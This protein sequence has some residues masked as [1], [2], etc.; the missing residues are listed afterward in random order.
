MSPEVVALLGAIAV[1]IAGVG[2]AYLAARSAKR[3]NSGNIQTSTAADLWEQSSEMNKSLFSQLTNTQVQLAATQIQLRDTSVELRDTT[4][5]LTSASNQIVDLIHK[6]DLSDTAREA[7]DL[8]RQEAHEDARKARDEVA[9]LRIQ[10]K[11]VRGQVEAVHEEIKTGN[12]LTL[13]ALADNAESRR[14]AIIPN[15]DRTE[16]E[17]AHID[18]VGIQTK[19]GE[20]A[21]QHDFEQD[22]KVLI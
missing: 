22:G 7:S 2:A 5:Q 9:S 16:A 19:T 14:I 17:H 15:K 11:M 4:R 13:G 18:T 10:I 12:A 20:R 6:V 21:D 3:T 1:I 8:S